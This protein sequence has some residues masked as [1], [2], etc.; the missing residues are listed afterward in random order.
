MKWLIVTR[1]LN[2]SQWK[3]ARAMFKMSEAGVTMCEII[4]IRKIWSQY[5]PFVFGSM[6]S[7]CTCCTLQLPFY[8]CRCHASGFSSVTIKILMSMRERCIKLEFLT[9]ITLRTC[10][11][12]Y[13]HSPVDSCSL[14]RTCSQ[15]FPFIQQ[16]T[17]G[18]LAW[19]WWHFAY[20]RK[21]KHML[22]KGFYDI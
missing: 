5:E 9:A 3:R 2:L 6:S 15:S 4:I 21:S 7:T 20:E 1:C 16:G 12:L 18:S 11:L 14:V 19:D 17:P 10:S 8:C 13:M 22:C